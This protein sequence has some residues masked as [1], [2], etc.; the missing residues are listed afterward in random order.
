MALRIFLAG[1]MQGSH[2]GQSLHD[3]TYRGKLK[4]LLVQYL[5]GAEIYDPLADHANSLEYGEDVGRD[6]FARHIQM[7][8]EYD[9]VLAYLPQASMG[10]AI[11]M[12][13]AWQRGR[14]V[15]TISPLIHN[16]VV[17]FCSHQVYP[18]LEA[19]ER[20]V[21]AGDVANILAEARE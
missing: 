12:W 9:V 14:V 19:F 1:I 20:A 10:T 18:D 17:R 16:W 5:P 11:E 2:L 6:V 15:L 7:C 3:Q 13:Q 8:A 4:E 21:R